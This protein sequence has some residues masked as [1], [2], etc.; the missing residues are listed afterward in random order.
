MKHSITRKLIAYFGILII[1]FTFI[2][3]SL[4]V[5]IFINQSTE[6]SIDDLK[7]QATQISKALSNN[8]QGIG[9]NHNQHSHANG[10]H[11]QYA[12]SI[13][14][15][16]AR[17]ISFLD[18]SVQGNVWIV[19]RN[20]RLV[21]VGHGKHQVNYSD[22]PKEAEML[23]EE[24]FA[25]ETESSQSFSSILEAPSVT[26]GAPIYNDNN[27]IVAVVLLHTELSHIESSIQDG[28]IILLT[29]LLISLVFILILSILLA[30]NFVRPL[31]R[32]GKV[33]EKIADGHYDVRTNIN[34]KDEIGS[35]ALHIDILAER[36]YE[37]D[38]Y[39]S[40]IERS[41]KDFMTKIAHELRTPVTVIRG[42]L[43]ALKDGV[44]R[45]EEKVQDYYNQM[46]LDSI[47]LERMINDLLELS[48][49]QNPD[50]VIKK[51]RV[52]VIEILSDALRSVRLLAS[53]KDIVLNYN[54]ADEIYEME[55]DY[56]RIRQMFVIV[57]DNAIKFSSEHS[58]ID[59]SIKTSENAFIVEVSDKGV[60]MNKEE[61]SN[62]FN[63]FYSSDA[64]ANGSGL[65]LA[66]AKEI[67]DRHKIKIEISSIVT[68]G[69][70]VTF[71]FEK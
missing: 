54:F 16:Y 28:I 5:Y 31:N 32:M 9:K 2:S 41:R 59:I 22:F 17:D 6:K 34:Q 45:E 65:G 63:K 42:S 44:V 53:N 40:H 38:K 21:H 46:L 8:N 37:N 26:I 52:N 11:N 50:Y 30:R 55:A 33:T 48:R 60:G 13:E 23:V 66:I 1:L 64:S 14:D 12:E 29:C 35:L 62:V 39:M 18:A 10:N 69:T 49:L 67:A 61:L 47:H 57:I 25:G 3:G 71:I 58:Q 15:D 20:V 4:F 19:D 70:K 56:A 51:A 36:L 68:I 24:A 43:E 27:E 7:N